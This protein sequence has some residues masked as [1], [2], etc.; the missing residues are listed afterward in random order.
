MGGWSERVM[1]QKGFFDVERR[2]DAIS[3]L[4]DPLETIKKIVPWED[5][6]TDIEAV[7]E[8]KPEERKSNAGRKPYDTI[9]KFKIM[10]LQSLHNL[11]RFLDLELEDPVPDATT[12]WLFR[13]ALAQAGL[14]D[15][16]FER[17]GQHLEAEGYIARGGQIIDA[18][19]VSVPKQRN[20]KEE[21]EA[22][23]AGK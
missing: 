20:T 9:L 13:E 18:T 23:K 4:G 22:I 8:T 16:L 17:F 12:I 6:R 7:T 1:G 14:I 11:M 2:L 3:A 21:N 15:K 10:V 19:I 5:F